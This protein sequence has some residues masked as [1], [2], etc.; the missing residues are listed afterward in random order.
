MRTTAHVLA[1]AAIAGVVLVTH[2]GCGDDPPELLV[3]VFDGGADGGD[4][5]SEAGPEVDPTLGGP[6]TETAQCDDGVPCTYD[7]CDQAIARC[8][9][10]PD[11]AQCDDGTFC[12]GKE[13][14]V[15]RRGCG[16]GPV[17]TCQDGDPCTIDT[18]VEATK[19]CERAVRDVDGDG[20][21]DDHCVGN[22][23][24]N[25]MDPSVSSQKTEVCEN[26]K[27]DDCDGVVDEQPC[28]RAESDVCGTARVVTSAG[29]VLLSTVAAKKDYATSCS[30]KTPAAGSDVVVE[31]RVP[32]VSTDPKKNVRVVATAENGTNEVAVALQTSCGAAGTEIACA[33]LP[34]TSEARAIAREVVPGTS[35][36]A[37]VTTQSE[38]NV[39][40]RVDF[41]EGGPRPTNETCASATPIALDA[42][43]DVA[44]IDAAKD[45]PSACAGAKT[46][47]LAYSFTLGETRD[48]RIF[49]STL[50]GQGIP[51]VSLRDP[52]DGSCATEL[53]CR[54]GSAPPVFARSLAAGTY[55][56]TVAGTTQL[57]ASVL[58][59]TYAPTP[60]PPTSSCATA[61]ALAPN[62][63]TAVDLSSLEDSIKNG[64]LG[65]G[66][67]AAY[68]LDLAAPSDVL[69]VGR[70]VLGT[71][72]GVSLNG[73]LCTSAD[74]LVCREQTTPV[75]V[76]KRNMA[77]GSYRVVVANEVGLSAEVTA[78]VRPTVAPTVVSA[79][80]GCAGTTV[81]PPAG[82]FF[83]GDT[84]G[85]TPDF[86][87][88]CDTAGT[89]VGGAAD[90]LLRLDLTA[91]KRVVLDMTGS[92]YTTLLAIRQGAACPGIEVPDAC[93]AGFSNLGRS[94]LERVLDPGTYWL[95]IDGYNGDKGQWN[96]DVRVLDP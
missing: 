69:V 49:A 93:W 61:P 17:V 24:C 91:R 76:S 12:N 43:F 8:R 59:K 2:A 94:F 56:F 83:T 62:V 42:P 55:V 79:S 4:A 87:S 14:C 7:T 41:D 84:T 39:S 80:D 57:D 44:L 88:A 51:V 85:K 46:G 53:R 28:A 23:D 66:L 9:N 73:P 58:V 31:I 11:D 78:F 40:V 81:V 15:P 68:A 27:D 38:G 10:V 47:E 19:G 25:D 3:R 50:S 37:V 48:V 33:A 36:F 5:A 75:R 35:L 71:A 6:C 18:C 64:C 65:G 1:A 72:G 86:G 52:A 45:V 60:A 96:L 13:V 89:G 22:R 67:A 74:L 82:G 34:S 26:G 90:Q 63:R 54:A 92:T 21:P 20:D 95:Q 16:P 29:A 77:P 30:V 32:G 70:F